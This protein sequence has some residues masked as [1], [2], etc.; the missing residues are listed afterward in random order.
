[1][2]VQLKDLEPVSVMAAVENRSKTLAYQTLSG[3]SIQVVD[4][5]RPNHDKVQSMT[6]IDLFLRNKGCSKPAAPP[7]TRCDPVSNSCTE[8][9]D[10]CVSPI[11]A[12]PMSLGEHQ[13]AI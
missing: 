5:L 11:L 12:V 9:N 1:M 8:Q 13:P 7:C 4:A 10:P 2:R 3:S 6:S